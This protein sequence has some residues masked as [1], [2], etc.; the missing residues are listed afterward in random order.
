MSCSRASTHQ[1]ASDTYLS[2]YLTCLS[3][4]WRFLSSA[5]PSSHPSLTSGC[6]CCA[7]VATVATFVVGLSSSSPISS[8]S[9]LLPPLFLL[10][11]L[12]FS[13]AFVSPFSVCPGH[14]LEQISHRRDASNFLH[15][16]PC[17]TFAFPKIDSALQSFG[18]GRAVFFTSH[19]ISTNF[20][21]LIYI[22]SQG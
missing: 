14:Q 9:S 21:F 13:L 6:Y 20:R 15:S 11:H 2:G 1:G 19:H 4:F 22:C 18:R 8:F 12:P 3:G 17:C 10:H 16:L 5:A 7:V